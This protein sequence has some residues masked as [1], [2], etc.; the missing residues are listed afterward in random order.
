[1]NNHR[2]PAK[3]TIFLT[4]TGKSPLVLHM[5]PRLF[6][7]RLACSLGFLSIP[8]VWACSIW[9]TEQQRNAQ[10]LEEKIAFQ[11]R[12]EQLQVEQEQL[13]QEIDRLR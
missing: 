4:R 12:Q 3:Y 10:Y 11:Q 6:L 2:L 13:Q 9:L 1:M 5:S 7:M 8:F